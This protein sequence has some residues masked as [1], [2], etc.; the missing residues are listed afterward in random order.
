M[1]RSDFAGLYRPARSHQ[2]LSRLVFL[3]V[4][5]YYVANPARAA[6]EQNGQQFGFGQG[7]GKA[8]SLSAVRF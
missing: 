6:P 5:A 7:R 2:P 4:C 1:P 3:V 8:F